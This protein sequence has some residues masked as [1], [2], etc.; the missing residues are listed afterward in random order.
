MLLR[1]RFLWTMGRLVRG[2]VSCMGLRAE[3]GICM[4]YA[5]G[6]QL[7]CFS[8]HHDVLSLLS[9]LP[10]KAF[11]LTEASHNLNESI[12]LINRVSP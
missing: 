6:V 12:P 2:G 11:A 10:F 3:R 9:L 4:V 5:T 7:G 1:R 8:N